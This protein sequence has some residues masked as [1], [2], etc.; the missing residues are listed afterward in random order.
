MTITD[1]EMRQLLPT[2]REYTVV[3]LRAGPERG[4]ADADAIVWEHGRRNFQLRRGGQLAVV[5]PIVDDSEV[6]GIGIFSTGV[7]ETKAIM[8][9][10]PGVQAG[11]FDYEV[12]PCR[13]F[14]G[15]R[16]PG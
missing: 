10:D 7:E 1:D 12:H 5:C 8:D 16:L 6:A 9:G 2:T 15:D 14:P 4:R 3:I 13:G 11:L